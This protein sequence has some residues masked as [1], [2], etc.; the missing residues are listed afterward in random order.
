MDAELEAAQ[1]VAIAAAARVRSK[2]AAVLICRWCK[3]EEEVY[4]RCVGRAGG[5]GRGGKQGKQEGEVGA[6][7]GRADRDAL[8]SAA[9]PRLRAWGSVGEGGVRVRGVSAL[10]AE[11]GC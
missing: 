6:V 2:P 9:R 7:P 5:R 3:G 10:A 4:R 11:L 8:A 1:G